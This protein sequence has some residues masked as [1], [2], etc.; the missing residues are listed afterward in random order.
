MAQR[1]G[2][3]ASR[4]RSAPAQA[5]AAPGG[6]PAAPRPAGVQAALDRLAAALADGDGRAASGLAPAGH[7]DARALLAAVARNAEDLDVRDLS[8]R[9]L[10]PLS[11]PDVRGEWT[12]SVRLRWRFAGYDPV[13]SV[14]TIVTRLRRSPGGRISVVVPAEAAGRVPVW[15]SG[16]VRVRRVTGALLV[17][18]AGVDDLALEERV[19]R[20]ARRAVP[21]VRRVLPDWRSPVV[22]EV[23]AGAAALDRALAEPAGTSLPV[24]AV[25]APVGDRG[26]A[27]HVFVNPGRLRGLRSIG[28]QVVLSHEVTHLATSA[29]GSAAPLWLVEGFADYVALRD[30]GLPVGSLAGTL[31]R[32]VRRSGIRRSLPTSHDFTSRGRRL[33]ATYEAAWLA[34]VVLART[35]GE[36]ALLALYRDADRGVD[37]D[38]AL[39]RHF[40]IGSEG[41]TALW[42]D[43]QRGLAP[44]RSAQ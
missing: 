19:L 14:T 3:E 25:T 41:L 28:A 27:V 26:S 36:G 30:V 20:L 1:T 4:S 29:A 24:A 34:C 5:T 16:P 32:E 12:A 31:V 37:I 42:R 43:R 7:A 21:V 33:G 18:G 44:R 17:G 9:H 10:S 13:A 8:L 38:L 2:D 22:V 6:R 23:P 35:G 40:G 39:Q 15:L 11:A